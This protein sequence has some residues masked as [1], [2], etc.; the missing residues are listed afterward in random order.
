MR[1][2]EA[3]RLLPG[4]ILSLGYIVFTVLAVIGIVNALNGKAKELP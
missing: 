3:K 4:T 1:V 2:E